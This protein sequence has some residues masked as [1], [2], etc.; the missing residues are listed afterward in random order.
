RSVVHCEIGDRKNMTCA[1]WRIDWDLSADA[2][3]FDI[4]RAQ[5]SCRCHADLQLARN[6]EVRLHLAADGKSC[7]WHNFA[8][9]KQRWIIVH[10]HAYLRDAGAFAQCYRNSR[11]G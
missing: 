3:Q 4:S 7:P 5:S 1:V 2:K 8:D 6:T 10:D 9:Q 11:S